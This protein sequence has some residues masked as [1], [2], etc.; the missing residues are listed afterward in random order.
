MTATA[1]GS[2]AFAGTSAY[3][4][5]T[6][7]GVPVFSASWVGQA[8]QVTPAYLQAS[9]QAA[10]YFSGSLLAQAGILLAATQFAGSWTG[11]SLSSGGTLQA[12][13]SFSAQNYFG[14]FLG[15]PGSIGAGTAF[16]AS[17]SVLSYLVSP[18]ELLAGTL[19]SCL[20]ST[21]P[22]RYQVGAAIARALVSAEIGAF[23]T[24][25]QAMSG[26]T[27]FAAD[28]ALQGLTAQ[29]TACVARTRFHG[30]TLK[31]F[32]NFLSDLYRANLPQEV[33]DLRRR[34]KPTRI[35]P[36][37]EPD[38]VHGPRLPDKLP[39]LDHW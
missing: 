38:P 20:F 3:P 10:A 11:Q 14:T 21:D 24:L 34:R 2:A 30:S 37:V 13:T 6:I 1:V 23:K 12:G 25:A 35:L 31:Y 28:Y 4:V 39:T 16:S 29:V 8:Q 27:Q 19:F 36:S 17:F 7:Q 9:T 18:E 22:S 15:T 32:Q 26:G 33:T 5:T